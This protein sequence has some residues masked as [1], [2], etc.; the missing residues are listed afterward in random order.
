M[1]MTLK[2][3]WGDYTYLF[4]RTYAANDLLPGRTSTYAL[5]MKA[6]GLKLHFTRPD[7][8]PLLSH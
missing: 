4:S 7:K 3:T 8:E 5:Q 2:I 6:R 1:P